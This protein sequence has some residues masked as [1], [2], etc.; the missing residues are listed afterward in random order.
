MVA[1]VTSKLSSISSSRFAVAFVAATAALIADSTV[2]NAVVAPSTVAFAVGGCWLE[3]GAVLGADLS[4]SIL[5]P[6]PPARDLARR[7]RSGPRHTNTPTVR[8]TRAAI[9]AEIRPMRKSSFFGATGGLSGGGGGATASGTETWVSTVTADFATT[10]TP[11]P[12]ELEIS[13]ASEATSALALATTAAAVALPLTGPSFGMV[14]V[15]ESSTLPAEM[16]TL[17]TQ[18]GRL[19]L[20]VVLSV[21]VIA[22]I[23]VGL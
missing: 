11:T 10:F 12:R 4:G 1:S 14:S 5:L 8:R 7:L 17:V 23:R 15:M 3:L 2:E 20:S 13:L 19:Q 21:S 18:I 22:I 6:P 9:R 16:R